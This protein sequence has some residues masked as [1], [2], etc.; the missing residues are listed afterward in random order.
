MKIKENKAM[1][2]KDIAELLLKAINW[3]ELLKVP[4]GR[5]HAARLIGKSRRTIDAYV[6]PSE[7]RTITAEDLQ[8][9]CEEVCRK[10]ALVGQTPL[11]RFIVYDAYGQQ[12][13][14]SQT[15]QGALYLAD[16][17]DGS[18]APS[19]ALH[20]T[21]VSDPVRPAAVLRSQLRRIMRSGHVSTEQ[22]CQVLGCCPYTLVMMQMESPFYPVHIDEFGLRFLQSLLADEL[23]EA[24]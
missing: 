9:I 20:V 24:A 13:A 6:A 8:V 3:L 21:D 10:M 4:N 5:D 17:E 2:E 18:F 22:A 19:P 1:S 7:N 23:G 15:A 11:M 14:R 12:T 16:L